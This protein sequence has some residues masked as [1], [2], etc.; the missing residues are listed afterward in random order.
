MDFAISLKFYFWR[1][2]EGIIMLFIGKM[3]FLIPI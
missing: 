3:A 2:V 1:F